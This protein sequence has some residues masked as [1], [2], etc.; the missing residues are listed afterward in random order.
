MKSR[1][2]LPPVALSSKDPSSRVGATILPE[3][4]S[5]VYKP[6]RRALE[7]SKRSAAELDLVPFK[8]PIDYVFN[9]IKD[10]P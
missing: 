5:D 2:R 6:P 10:Q 1:L 8:C 9:A 3:E 7:S 4:E